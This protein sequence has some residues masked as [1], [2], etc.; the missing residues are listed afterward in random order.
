MLAS[1]VAGAGST[2]GPGVAAPRVVFS[3]AT[4]SEALQVNEVFT[5]T[6]SFGIAAG[7]YVP[8]WVR[9]ADPNPAPSYLAVLTPTITGAARYSPTIDTVEWQGVLIP[10]EEPLE[11]AFQV[12]VLGLPDEAPATGYQITNTATIADLAVPGSLPEQI[13]QATVT[14]GHP[15]IWLPIVARDSGP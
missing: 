11:V 13:A 8:I 7:H 5:F 9:V 10:G 15:R 3:K 14:L 6:L 4:S 12:R 2:T 1:A